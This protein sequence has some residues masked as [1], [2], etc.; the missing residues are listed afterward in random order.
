VVVVVAGAVV[1]AGSVVVV[2]GTVVV[3]GG[4]VVVVTG[5]VVVVTGAVVVVGSADPVVVVTPGRPL[6]GLVVVVGGLVVAVTDVEGRVGGCDAE[7]QPASA[8]APMTSVEI[9]APAAKKRRTLLDPTVGPW[10]CS[11]AM[12][13]PS[14]TTSWP[15]PPGAVNGRS[16]ARRCVLL[17]FN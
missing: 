10:R 3:V 16:G 1:V 6:L 8:S 9:A 11:P 7:V 13:L 17:D 2:A 12:E 15:V 5:V 14:W 4:L